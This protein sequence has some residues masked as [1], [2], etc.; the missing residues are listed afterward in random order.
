MAPK[1]IPLSIFHKSFKEQLPVVEIFN[2]LS[3]QEAEKS[4]T[5][6][7]RND[8][9]DDVPL[10]GKCSSCPFNFSDRAEQ[11]LHYKS[12]WHGYNLKRLLKFQE[13]ISEDYFVS[14]VIANADSSSISGSDSESSDHELSDNCTSLSVTD[15]IP[16]NYQMK[17]HLTARSTDTILSIHKCLVVRR[18]EQISSTDALI[19]RLKTLFMREVIRTVVVMLSSGHFA[20]AVFENETAI[21]HKTFHKYVVRAKQGTSQ[22]SNDNRGSKAK[23]AGANLRRHCE[24]SLKEDITELLKSWSKHLGDANLIF[25]KTS[26]ENSSVFF[27][28]KNPILSKQDERVRNI[29]FPTRRPTFSELKRVFQNLTQITELNKAEYVESKLRKKP[30]SP[31]KKFKEKHSCVNVLH[32]VENKEPVRDSDKEVKDE[33]DKEQSPIQESQRESP[34]QTPEEVENDMLQR[35][36]DLYTSDTNECFEFVLKNIEDLRELKF[37]N[38]DSC[39]HFFSLSNDSRFIET[40]LENG[41]DLTEKNGKNKAPCQLVSQKNARN[42]FRRFRA[43][44]PDKY[45]YPVAGVPEP[46]NEED[47][48]SRAEKLAQKRKENK[49]RRKETAKVVKDAAEIEKIEQNQKQEFLQL[50]DREKRALAAERRLGG[51]SAS[52]YALRCFLCGKHIESLIPFKY[53]DNS[54]CSTDCVHVHRKASNNSKQ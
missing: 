31:S 10:T 4:E 17:L 49:Q 44:Y 21:V 33:F 27:G 5:D 13:P 39:L 26:T 53:S 23:S 37:L 16:I 19:H 43:K 18:K 50:S 11:I 2:C 15:N 54:F 6:V 29:P 51:N 8:E 30:M 35:V 32:S 45:N 12:D 34:Q 25:I 46:L 47:E 48:K 38:G 41:F 7:Q 14:T 3:T 40:L 9:L 20:A 36:K 24:A 52:N 42:V 1:K 22:S 28:G